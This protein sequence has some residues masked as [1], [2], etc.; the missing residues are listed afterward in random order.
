MN[1]INQQKIQHDVLMEA[2]TKRHAPVADLIDR[3]S[4]HYVDMPVHSN[5]GDLLIMLGTLAFF[6]KSR[7]VPKLQAA[8]FNYDPSWASPKDVLVFQG[9]GNMGDLYSACQEFRETAISVARHSRI[10]ILPQTIHFESAGNLLRC[11]QVCRKHPDLHIFAR[12]RRSYALAQE[13]TDN[14]YLAPDMAHQLWGSQGYRGAP[15]SER[16]GKMSLIRTDAESN[17]PGLTDEAQATDW[18]SLV[19]KRREFAI[20]YSRALLSRLHLMKINRLVLNYEMDLWVWF[21]QRLVTEAAA[22]FGGLE[23]VITDR[24]HGHILSCLLET[25]SKV[26]DN[27]YGKNSSYVREWTARSDLVQTVDF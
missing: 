23:E 1:K 7:V 10:I 26:I 11:V 6:D 25:P 16:R 22:M 2:L 24:L 5:I 4:V 14:A 13:M 20:R 15:I 3:R 27:E 9:G 12:D 21:A 17:N 18:P 8:Y 19:G